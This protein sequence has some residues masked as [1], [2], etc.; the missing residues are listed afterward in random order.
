MEVYYITKAF[1]FGVGVGVRH[2]SEENK[3]NTEHPV[4]NESMVNGK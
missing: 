3:V 2:R 4:N 1:I